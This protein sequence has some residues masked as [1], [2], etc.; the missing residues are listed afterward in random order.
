MRNTH[1][2]LLLGVGITISTHFL[3]MIPCKL[4]K[5]HEVGI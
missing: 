4:R 2:T 3:G 5:S 1:E